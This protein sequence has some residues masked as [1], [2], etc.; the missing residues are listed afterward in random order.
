MHWAELVDHTISTRTHGAELFMKNQ[1]ALVS[2]WFNYTS[3]SIRSLDPAWMQALKWEGE[4]NLT[5]PFL[6]KGSVLWPNTIH[7][8]L[9]VPGNRL[10][11]DW[12][13]H[14]SSSELTQWSKHHIYLLLF[15]QV[16]L[17]SFSTLQDKDNWQS[18]SW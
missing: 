4:T 13:K 3:K 17:L 11:K 5:L 2:L 14:F 8:N 7:E 1:A 18:N 10:A 9:I 16:N 6:E 12:E 15:E